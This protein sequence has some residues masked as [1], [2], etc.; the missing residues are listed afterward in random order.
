MAKTVKGYYENEKDSSTTLYLKDINRI[1]LLSREDEYQL[2][3]AA[4]NGDKAAKNKIVNSNL[5][6]VVNIAKQYQGRGLELMDLIS[7]GN[8][9]LLTAIEKFD[10][11]KGYHFISYAV[12]WIRQSI[13]K[14]IYEKGRAIRL[15]LNRVNEVVQIEKTRKNLKGDLSEEEELSRVADILGMDASHVREMILISREMLSLD[16]AVKADADDSNTMADFIQDE[17]YES[18]VEFTERNDMHDKI[19][20]A[21]ATLNYREAEILRY[22]F[23]LDGRK[24]L[25]LKEVGDI[26]NLTKERVRQ[27]EKK[28][29]SRLQNQKVLASLEGFAA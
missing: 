5:R 21:L 29:L 10:V 1:P 28:A 3:M 25:S 19:N 23:G 13:L 18:P 9:G 17:L 14:A 11:T 24:A 6:F 12:W 4:K 2:A 22:R 26:F 15:P 7:E 8:V 20:D 16:S 27:I